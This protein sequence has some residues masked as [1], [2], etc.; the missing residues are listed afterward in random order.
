MRKT[1]HVTISSCSNKRS[2][3][4]H[5]NPFSVLAVLLLPVL[6]CTMQEANNATNGSRSA[7][8]PFTAKDCDIPGFPPPVAAEMEIY[9]TSI[10]CPFHSGKNVNGVV[11]LSLDY[12]NQADDAT[13]NYNMWRKNIETSYPGYD[14]VTNSFYE[15]Y[16]IQVTKKIG[17]PTAS[18]DF[19]AVELYR[20]HFVILFKGDLKDT[21]QDAAMD[22][23]QALE[24]YATGI[25][26]DH[27]PEGQ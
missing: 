25:A 13:N 1:D 4:R 2:A 7:P 22:M 11:Y 27:Y 21:S 20:D 10:Y 18:V 12:S 6:A 24:T 5:F 16:K 8:G 15:L 23:V 14:I 26:Y 3:H 17:D 9:P 19:T